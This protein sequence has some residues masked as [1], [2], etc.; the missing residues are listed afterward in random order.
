MRD[1]AKY[2]LEIVTRESR[3]CYGSFRLTLAA[4]AAVLLRQGVTAHEF[5]RWADEAFVHA[6][7]GLLR[8]Q[9]REPS[10][11]RISAMTGIQRHAVSTLLGGADGERRGGPEE[12][13]YQRHRLARVLTGWFEDPAF[14]DKMGRPLVLPLDGPR[15]S[16]A[17]LVRQYSGDI[18]PGIILE[19]LLRV[20]A[21]RRRKNGSVEA[22]SRRYMS[23]G[24]D[25]ASV[26]HA[27]I[28][29][30]DVLR[31]LEHNIRSEPHERLYEDSA[32]GAKLPSDVV[33]R[34]SRLLERRAAA[35]LD[36][37]D[38]WLAELQ[39]MPDDGPEPPSATSPTLR[40]GVR[41][42]MVV[43]PEGGDSGPVGSSG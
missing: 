42:I 2:G 20:G 6:A 28:V 25:A 8:E 37:L 34:L 21:A 27:D 16:F 33:P 23:G 43:E 36:D 4:L 31:T 35:F 29:A 11:S 40:A 18:Y 32:I 22:R 12:K 39:Q 19:E 9:G 7:L 24:T 3:L 38:G 10:F 30:A 13:E 17:E 15:P 41:V 26:G 14:T 1:L 5:A